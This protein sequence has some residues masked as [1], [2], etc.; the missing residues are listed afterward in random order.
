MALPAAQVPA[1]G[2]TINHEKGIRPDC[3]RVACLKV[4]AIAF[5]FHMKGVKRNPDTARDVKLPPAPGAASWPAHA[6]T[7]G[8]NPRGQSQTIE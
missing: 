1:N 3:D 5:N 2:C 4:A 6:P 8:R 7:D